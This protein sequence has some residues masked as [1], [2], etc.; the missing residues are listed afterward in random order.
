MREE[1]GGRREEG[2]RRREEGGGRDTVEGG[3]WLHIGAF[4][5]EGG[6][7]ERTKRWTLW[8]VELEFLHH[9]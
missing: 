5:M 1:R 4:R 8:M 7:V 2:G 3:R 9:C 6:K